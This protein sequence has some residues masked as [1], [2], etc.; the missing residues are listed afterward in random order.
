MPSIIQTDRIDNQAGVGKVQLTS[1]EV[2]AKRQKW[3]YHD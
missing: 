3:V 1:G 2:S